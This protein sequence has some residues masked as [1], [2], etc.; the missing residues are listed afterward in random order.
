[1]EVGEPKTFEATGV[2]LD[3]IELGSPQQLEVVVF[4]D[5]MCSLI[6]ERF[7]VG[8]VKF[9]LPS[10]ATTGVGIKVLDGFAAEVAGAMC[11]LTSSAVP[12]AMSIA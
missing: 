4:A 3:A 2:G 1:M 12:V 11:T 7:E 8:A 5:A 10:L 6:D 9:A